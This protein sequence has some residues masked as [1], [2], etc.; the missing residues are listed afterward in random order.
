M[1]PLPSLPCSGRCG[2]EPKPAPPQKNL[3]QHA[4]G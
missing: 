2:R 4:T 1:D 3:H